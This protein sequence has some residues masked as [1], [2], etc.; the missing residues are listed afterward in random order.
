MSNNGSNSM[1]SG[2]DT[3]SSSIQ[4]N[5]NNMSLSNNIRD[6]SNLS[7]AKKRRI[8]IINLFTNLKFIILSTKYENISVSVFNSRNT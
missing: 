5:I 1:A 2:I 7:R 4:N 6:L 3:F 8:V